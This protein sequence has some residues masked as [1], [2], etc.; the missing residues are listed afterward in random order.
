[1]SSP[2]TP[3]ARRRQ[4]KLS[5][6]DPNGGRKGTAA[7]TADVAVDLAPGFAAQRRFA[8][9]E[10]EAFFRAQVE[11][12]IPESLA[13]AHEGLA[14]AVLNQN[15]S[16]EAVAAW[17]RAYQL[18]Q[19]TG[20]RRGAARVA[21]ALG[22]RLIA[23]AGEMAVGKGWLRRASRLLEGDPRAPERA[24][25]TFWEAH[26]A[27]LYESDLERGR[28]LIGQSLE[29]ARELGLSDLEL[30]ASGLEG[31]VLVSQGAPSEGMPRLDETTTAALAG[32][33]QNLEAL[34]HACCYTLRACELTRDYDRGASWFDRMIAFGGEYGAHWFR[35]YCRLDHTAVQTWRGEWDEVERDLRALL[36]EFEASVPAALPAVWARMADILRLRGRH[37]EAAEL[38]DRGD[39][40]SGTPLIRAAL[41]LDRGDPRSAVD[42]ANRYL[43]MLPPC[44]PLQQAPAWE[45][46]ARA[47]AEAGEL[48]ASRA[49]L[50]SLL[51][52]DRKVGTHGLKA[53]RRAA[54]AALARAEG[55]R[56]DARMALEDA[57]TL[58]ERSRAPYE[59]AMARLDLALTLAELGRPE[60]AEAQIHPALARLEALGA[61]C[62]VRRAK[63][64]LASLR[65]EAEPT[66]DGAWSGLT[67]RQ[68]DVLRLVARGLS[69]REIGE[70]LFLSPHT[71]KRHIADILTRLDLPTRAAA[72]SH[73]VRAG[74]A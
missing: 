1:M 42:Q 22:L 30:T 55:R 39:G 56:E 43:R 33:I 10:S 15:R 32:E 38:L 16:S 62:A 21:T 36:P 25:L 50:Q 59:A 13:L 63:A 68:L 65:P 20:D 60:A 34:G 7:S 41:A 23:Y 4:P 29:L 48:E 51:D 11:R 40:W 2:T 70:H 66:P 27:Y 28:K 37:D 12:G 61:A 73:A 69:N 19:A 31:L 3:A 18:Y 46:L 54:E 58:F 6:V 5:L 9:A 49:A 71:V 17:T 24:W 14:I 44:D 8:W 52:L 74:L 72:A 47:A 67:A 57:V 64:L 45:L 26:L 35:A 53:T